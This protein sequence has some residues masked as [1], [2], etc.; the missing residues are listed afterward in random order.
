M[1]TAISTKPGKSDSL[2]LYRNSSRVQNGIA[3]RHPTADAVHKASG[4]K[5]FVIVLARSDKIYTY[6]FETALAIAAS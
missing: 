1:G 2:L 4:V 3:F 6:D 5:K